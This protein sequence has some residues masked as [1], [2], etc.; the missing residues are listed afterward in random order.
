[1]I[2]EILSINYQRLHITKIIETAVL[3]FCH[4]LITLNIIQTRS[5]E[6]THD[7]DHAQISGRRFDNFA[8]PFS[9]YHADELQNG[10]ELWSSTAICKGH[11]FLQ[12]ACHACKQTMSLKQTLKA[13]RH[14]D[15]NKSL[16]FIMY[17]NCLPKNFHINL[18]PLGL[19]GGRCT[20]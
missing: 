14:Y 16:R 3:A 4:A 1:M 18:Q 9:S 12:Q 11:C 6:L 15:Y 10:Q 19:C 5:H 13:V 8:L 20:S 7:K 2:L 17:S